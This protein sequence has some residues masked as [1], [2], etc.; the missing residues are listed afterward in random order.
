MVYGQLGHASSFFQ[1]LSP[2]P[3]SL[4]LIHI[5]P[6]LSSVAGSLSELRTVKSQLEGSHFMFKP[7]SLEES[8]RTELTQLKHLVQS[9][10]PSTLHEATKVGIAENLAKLF[11]GQVSAV[12]Y[13][14]M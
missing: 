13:L 7:L 1:S 12:E 10:T 5:H 11:S 14:C 6:A 3:F 8:R 4:S 9:H 2:P